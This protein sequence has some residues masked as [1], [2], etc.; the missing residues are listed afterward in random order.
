MSDEALMVCTTC[1]V[2]PAPEDRDLAGL[3]WARGKESGRVVW[4]CPN[5]CRQYLRSIEGKLDSQW[6]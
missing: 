6:W 5:C 1:G 3:T 2:V 4:T